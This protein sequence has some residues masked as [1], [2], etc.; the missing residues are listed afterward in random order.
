MKKVLT[1]LLIMFVT[2]ILSACTG[3]YEED[4]AYNIY[5]EVVSPNEVTGDDDSELV[6][7]DVL[8]ENVTI[9]ATDYSTSTFSVDVD[10]ASYSYFRSYLNQ[11]YI[12]N[13]ENVRTEEMVNYFDYNYT[14]PFTDDPFSITTELSDTPWNDDTDLLMIGIK[15]KEVSYEASGNNNFVFLID[16]SG[17]MNSESKIGMAIDS[18]KL[19]V[20][21]LKEGDYVSIVTYAGEASVVLEQTPA[22]NKTTIFDALDSIEVGGSTN[23]SGGIE[24]AYNLAYDNF[25]F[26]G[27]NRVIMATDGDFNVGSTSGD[28]LV[29]IV[30]EKAEIGIY[31]TILSFGGSDYGLDTMET[32]SN[33][34]QGNY[35]FIDSL[36]EAEK[37]FDKDMTATLITIAEDVKIQIEFN[38]DIIETYRLIGYENRVLSNDDF[39]N[40][41]VD[42]GEIGSG[43]TITAFYEITYKEGYDSGDLGQVNIRYKDVGEEDSKLITGSISTNSYTTNP[44]NNFLFAAAVV[45]VSLLLRDSQYMGDASYQHALTAIENNLGTDEY[46]FRYEFFE[47][48]QTL[49]ELKE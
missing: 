28:D 10:T 44:S 46:G 36:K 17:S 37:V 18:Y 31:L 32:L 5:P 23:G 15:G 27:N 48:V 4:P 24:T 26:D 45:E 22:Q 20:E 3:S 6:V 42:A 25:I 30:K 19:L 9:F 41:D 40:D 16:I 35:F 49:Q 13:Y 2:I 21:N 29:A 7:G 38:A 34:G 33:E 1:V 47:L 8:K 39:D 43:H 12:P 14:P 11:G